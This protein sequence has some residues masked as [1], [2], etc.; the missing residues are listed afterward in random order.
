MPPLHQLIT[1][2]CFHMIASLEKKKLTQKLL[3]VRHIRDREEVT[4]DARGSGRV[5]SKDL[6]SSQI[7]LHVWRNS[8]MAE[9]PQE[10]LAVCAFI[11]A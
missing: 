4:C 3:K 11:L 1:A 8:K 2:I 6:L 10:K 7:A 5:G 9:G